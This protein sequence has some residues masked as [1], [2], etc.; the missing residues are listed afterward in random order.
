M[1][2]SSGV[3]P[4]HGAYEYV[5]ASRPAAEQPR[6]VIL[7]R[8]AKLDYRC[9]V[10]ANTAQLQSQLWDLTINR[11]GMQKNSALIYVISNF[12]KNVK[13]ARNSMPW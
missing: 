12:T 5:R 4:P 13:Y 2:I 6:D 1:H 8:P 3:P 11:K 10:I 9:A 7:A